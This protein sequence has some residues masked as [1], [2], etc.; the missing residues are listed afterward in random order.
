MYAPADGENTIHVDTLGAGEGALIVNGQPIGTV[1]NATD[2]TVFLSGGVNKVTVTGRSGRLFLDR[3]RVQPSAGT[4]IS[5]WY[6]AEDATLTGSATV[7]AYT[8]A[9]GGKAVTG[10]GGPPGNG[11]ALT[12]AATAPA[13]G[14]YALTV[15]YSNPEQSP[16]SHY[17]PDPLA[18]HADISV[19]GAPPHRVLFPHTFHANNFWTLTLPIRL[20]AGHNT[21]RFTA[22]E[23]PDFDGTTYI[24]DRY[25]DLDLRSAYASVIDAIAITPYTARRRRS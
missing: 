19:N 10:V 15:R 11:N 23:P 22:A 4:L 7:T 12:F 1:R 9:R 24:S 13:P 20:A 25:P 2:V 8:L 17:N 3:L 16:A 18:R 21:I 14:I 6:G 5:R